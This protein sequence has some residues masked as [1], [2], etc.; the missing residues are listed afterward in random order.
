MFHNIFLPIG[1]I[2]KK[3]YLARR[4]EN[5]LKE[6]LQDGVIDFIPLIF[7]NL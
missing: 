7:S 5:S 3:S 1:L 2:K 6:M 4:F